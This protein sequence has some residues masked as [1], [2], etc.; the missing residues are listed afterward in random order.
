MVAQFVGKATAT[1]QVLPTALLY[2]RTLQFCTTS[3]YQSQQG[4]TSKFNT[5]VQLN[6]TSK[7]YLLS[8]IFSHKKVPVNP[9]CFSNSTCDHRV[10]Q[11]QQGLRCNVKQL[12]EI[13]WVLQID[14]WLLTPI[15]L[16][17]QEYLGHIAFW[18]E[19]SL[20]GPLSLF[21]PLSF[22]CPFG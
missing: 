2:Y 11:V 19:L 16:L 13:C 14:H 21:A 5:V 1:I 4:V 20:F 3:M 15:L 7:S 22:N 18:R 10:W 6:P 12:G 17:H 9:D 8:W